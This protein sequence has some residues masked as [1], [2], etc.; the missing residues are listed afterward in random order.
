MD[1]TN[2]KVR[3]RATMI[4]RN[5]LLLSDRSASGRIKKAF[6]KAVTVATQLAIRAQRALVGNQVDV[7]IQTLVAR[8]EDRLIQPWAQIALYV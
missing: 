5:E 1:D 7:Q 3:Y 6:C 2:S 4:S 8:L